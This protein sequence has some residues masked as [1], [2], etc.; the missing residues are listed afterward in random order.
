[1]EGVSRIRFHTLLASYFRQSSHQRLGAPP[2]CQ[3]SSSSIQ[4]TCIRNVGS[5]SSR[6]VSSG[7]KW[8]NWLYM[9]STISDNNKRITNENQWTLSTEYTLTSIVSTLP[10]VVSVGQWPFIRPIVFN[11]LLIVIRIF[12]Y[13]YHTLSANSSGNQAQ[14][15]PLSRPWSMPFGLLLLLS[16]RKCGSAP[17]VRARLPP[18]HL[19]ACHPDS[20]II[21]YQ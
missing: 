11:Y 2:M 20:A 10:R 13:R 4:Y 19:V 16:M 3:A 14:M 9:T 6:V 8:S 17:I 21:R 15:R 7:Y 18:S 12:Y 5:L 1:M